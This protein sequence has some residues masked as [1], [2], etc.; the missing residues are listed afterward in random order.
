MPPRN[1]EACLGPG[2]S[3]CRAWTEALHILNRSI[4]DHVAGELRIAPCDP[5]CLVCAQIDW[6]ARTA[7]EL[8][9]LPQLAVCKKH[10]ATE[11]CAV[12]E[13]IRQLSGR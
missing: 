9:E 8:P 11:P 6:Q 12:C 4:Q 7:P 2:C 3:C 1:P 13:R 10:D 5:E